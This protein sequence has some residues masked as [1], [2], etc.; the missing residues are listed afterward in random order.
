[1]SAY[2]KEIGMDNFTEFKKS[3]F[4]P[5]GWG[6]GVKEDKGGLF[7]KYFLK[8]SSSVKYLQQMM[9]VKY[10][11]TSSAKPRNIPGFERE[12]HIR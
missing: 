11:T 2:P 1:M 9:T 7:T 5:E 12:Y 3:K 4:W 6:L 8:N 10:L